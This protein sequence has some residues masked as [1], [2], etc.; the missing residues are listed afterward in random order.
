M[1][2]IVEYS[3]RAVT[4]RHNSPAQVGR[5]RPLP[6]RSR[7]YLVEFEKTNPMR[8]VTNEI[9]QAHLKFDFRD[10]ALQLSKKRY[11]R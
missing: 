4:V 10:A 8:V 5:L 2:E 1:T 9:F 11:F 3:R 6:R 7:D